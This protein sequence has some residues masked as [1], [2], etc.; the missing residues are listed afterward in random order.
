[1]FRVVKKR[2]VSQDGVSY[3]GYGIHGEKCTVEDVTLCRKEAKKLAQTCNRLQVP[4]EEIFT[5]A[6]D[7]VQK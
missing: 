3:I 4:E 5:I 6:E 2:Y 1:M 7:F